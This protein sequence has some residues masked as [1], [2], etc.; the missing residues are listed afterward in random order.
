[1]SLSIYE[2]VVQPILRR[3]SRS[4]NDSDNPHVIPQSSNRNGSTT[5]H[6]EEVAIEDPLDPGARETSLSTTERGRVVRE[7]TLTYGNV[8][9]TTRT[10]LVP[11]E[12]PVPSPSE[13]ELSNPHD[14]MEVVLDAGPASVIRAQ[15]VLADDET[16][17]NPSHG[18]PQSLRS[19][20]TSVSSSAPSI[21]D[22]EMEHTEGISS[23][24]QSR[25]ERE[26]S[27]SNCN[28]RSGDGT[29]PADDGM[30]IMRKRILEIQKAEGSQEDKSRRMHALMTEQYNSSQPSLQSP[31]LGPN[32]PAS[33]ISHERPP[34]P[35]SIIS[36]NFPNFG[37][38]PPTLQSPPVGSPLTLHVSAEDRKVTRY[39]KNQTASAHPDSDRRIPDEEG[40]S[41]EIDEST[42]PFGCAH[43]KRNIKLQ[44]SAC[45][46]WY[47]CR[48]CHDEVE[49]HSLNRRETKNMLCMFCGCPQKASDV[50][51]KCGERAA[52]YYC[53]VCKLWDDDP[54]RSIYHCDD[55]GICR[56]GEGLGKDFFHCKVSK[57]RAD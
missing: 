39:T 47:T 34:T 30:S 25:R 17:S 4:S 26:G 33:S 22:V 8:T 21:Q 43:Y 3:L 15:T 7:P 12:T 56:V 23:T 29:L 10:H 32:S 38:S 16:S 28:T 9:T 24:G 6:Q 45:G 48:F 27:A 37:T 53:G 51:E 55:C 36:I 52:W 50:C 13:Y 40:D 1:M 41:S 18:I 44:C 49:D 46:R 54:G 42:L 2:S 14:S 31:R 20:A 57:V 35:R 19:Q 5:S 11:Q